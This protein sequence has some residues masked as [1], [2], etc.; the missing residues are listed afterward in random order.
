MRLGAPNI[1]GHHIG[2]RHGNLNSTPMEIPAAIVARQ[3]LMDIDLSKVDFELTD[4]CSPPQESFLYQ[5]LG[6][7]VVIV[8]LWRTPLLNS[9]KLM[10]VWLH[11]FGH[12]SACWLTGGVVLSME[13]KLSG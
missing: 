1:A 4:C 6:F 2:M 5:V 10:T 7:V 8:V 3:L 11:E 13:G 9:P 12:I